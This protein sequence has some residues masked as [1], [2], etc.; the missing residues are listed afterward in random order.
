MVTD[1]FKYTL[2]NIHPTWFTYRFDPGCYIESITEGVYTIIADITDMYP[3]TDRYFRVF[4]VFNLHFYRT[5]HSI[6]TTMKDAECTVT[7]KLEDFA[8]IFFVKGEQ[9]TSMS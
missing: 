3:N 2:R 7:E 4:L 9:D 1:I 6:D 8:T 5:F